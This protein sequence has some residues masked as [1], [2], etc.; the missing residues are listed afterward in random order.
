LRGSN[1]NLK[2]CSVKTILIAGALALASTTA[3]AAEDHG[4]YINAGVGEATYDIAKSDLDDLAEFAFEDNGAILLAPESSYEDTGDAISVAVGYRFSRYIAVEAGYVDLGSAEY[5][6]ESP[7]IIPGL[8]L[9]DASLGIDISAKGPTL[10]A[11]GFIPLG[12]KFDLHGHLGIL[13]SDLEFDVTV[14]LDDVSDRQS[15]S[16]SSEDV[17][18]GVGAAFHFTKNFA[19]SLDYSLFQ[20]VGDEEETGEGDIDALRLSLQYRF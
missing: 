20:D 5:R 12:E 19:V 11:A 2:E 13:F 8:G 14:G 1:F 6:A 17:F 3:M 4:F 18:A 7:A 10:A 15:F 16:A 9:L